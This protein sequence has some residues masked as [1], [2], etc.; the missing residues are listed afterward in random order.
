MD[1]IRL[2]KALGSLENTAKP[3]I[4]LEQYP[5]DISASVDFLFFVDSFGGLK[6]KNLAD[7]GC[8]NGIL[9]IGA[10]LLGAKNV[11]LF[12]IDEDMVSLTEKNLQKLG[13]DNCKAVKRDFF[14]V[15]EKYETVI[16]NPPFGFQSTFRIEAFISK[17]NEAG[18]TFYFIYKSNKEIRKIA[19]ENSLSVS[20]L[21]H[22]NLPK[23]AR[24]HR[25]ER[26]G[27]PICVV[28]KAA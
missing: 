22:L 20:E 14:D 13:L 24:F 8:G 1:K 9:G 12:D 23:L 26:L 18:D 16:S 5:T 27:L 21:G 2:S 25:K 19:G 6:D 17:L 7:F 3:K 4:K 28:Y 15:K 10:A 11:T